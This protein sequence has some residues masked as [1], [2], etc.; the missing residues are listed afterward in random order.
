MLRRSYIFLSLTIL[1][2]LLAGGALCFI[3][4]GELHLLLCDHHTAAGDFFFRYYTV[5]GEWVPYVIAVLLL[6]YRKEWGLMVVAGIVLSGLTT[7]VLKHIV[8]APRPLTWFAAAMPDVTLPL[9]DGVRMSQFYS[10]PSGHTTSFFALFLILCWVAGEALENRIAPPAPA[11]PAAKR[12]VAWWSALVQ[13]LFFT[14]A[15]L[16]GYSRIYLSQHFLLDVAAGALVGVLITL[17]LLALLP[18][19][20]KLPVKR[21]CSN[22]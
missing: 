20:S 22:K 19:F 2:L 3:P 21:F 7:Q 8:D 16:G 12:R 15:L 11:S 9:V 1:F 6:L 5:V 10:F 4:K 17:A 14:L 18:L 13:V